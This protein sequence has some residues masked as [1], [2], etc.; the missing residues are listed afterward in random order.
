M[1]AR[2]DHPAFR[3]CSFRDTGILFPFDP[4]PGEKKEGIA[5]NRNVYDLWFNMGWIYYHKLEDY[6]EG[7][8]YFRGAMRLEHPTYIDRLVAHAYRKNGDIEAEY[9]E[10]Q[11]CLTVFKDDDYHIDISERHLEKARDKLIKAGKI[12]PAAG[13]QATDL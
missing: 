9:E 7:V 6:M 10:W 13:Q 11:R 2:F 8:R 3:R 5:K 4:P 1:W 12:K